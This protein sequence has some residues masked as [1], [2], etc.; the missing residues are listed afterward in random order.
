MMILITY[1]VETV[2]GKGQKRLRQVAKA[3]MNYGQR[4]QNSVFECVID[5]A[6]FITLKHQIENIIDENADSVRFYLM[7]KNWA[8]KV[9]QIGKKTSYNIE[10]ELII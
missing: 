3:C 5:E 9:I 7:G 6:H 2:T 10:S 4:V 8:R 1:D